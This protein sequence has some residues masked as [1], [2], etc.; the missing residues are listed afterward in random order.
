MAKRIILI[1]AALAGMTAFSSEAGA[2]VC[3]RGVYLD[4]RIFRER[5]QFLT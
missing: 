4:R 1:L 3:A 2:V 5:P